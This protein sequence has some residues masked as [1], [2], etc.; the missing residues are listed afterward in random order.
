MIAYTIEATIKRKIFDKIFISTDSDLFAEI[1][2]DYEDLVP[3][4]DQVTYLIA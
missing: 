2:K 4:H 3:F 1:A